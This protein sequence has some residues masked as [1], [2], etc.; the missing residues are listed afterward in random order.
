MINWNEKNFRNN[1][2][3]FSNVDGGEAGVGYGTTYLKT[4]SNSGNKN[5]ILVTLHEFHHG[6]GGEYN[7]VPG[8]SN[9]HYTD[10]E[11]VAQLN[12]S[13]KLAL[14]YAHNKPDCPQLHDV[15]F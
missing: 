1:F 6:M 15:A 13:R 7:C 4:S 14:T 3:D 11:R 5:K 9:L 10:R 8:I 12:K 2:A